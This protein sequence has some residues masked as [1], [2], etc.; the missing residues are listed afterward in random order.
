MNLAAGKTYEP[1][2]IGVD[3]WSNGLSGGTITDG[4]WEGVFRFLA[5]YNR[6]FTSIII[7]CTC[8]SVS[9]SGWTKTATGAEWTGS[10]SASDRDIYIEC[11]LEDV[12]KIVFNY[13]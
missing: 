2:T 4:H 13:Q 10:G 9:R 3:L 12:E 7:T 6:A 8:N 11:D 1:L 5:P